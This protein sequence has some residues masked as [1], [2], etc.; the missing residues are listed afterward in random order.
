M[1]R[2]LS[3]GQAATI[4]MSEFNARAKAVSVGKA[5]PVKGA[6]RRYNRARTAPRAAPAAEPSEA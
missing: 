6:E 3:T 4:S 2:A 1:M 5:D